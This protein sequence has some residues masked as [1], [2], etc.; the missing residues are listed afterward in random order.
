MVPIFFSKGTNGHQ[1]RWNGRKLV[2]SL[3]HWFRRDSRLKNWVK[4]FS[5]CIF[6]SF[7]FPFQALP[8][9]SV[10]VLVLINCCVQSRDFGSITTG[11][12]S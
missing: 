8:N 5:S 7:F 10:L 2:Q 11:E 9:L 1:G 6:L 12:K 4:N 3:G